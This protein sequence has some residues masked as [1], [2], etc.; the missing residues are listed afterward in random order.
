MSVALNSAAVGAGSIVSAAHKEENSVSS[1]FSTMTD[2]LV[3]TG[4]FALAAALAAAAVLVN[5][6]SPQG[7]T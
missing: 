6:R 4:F 1:N 7:R 5:R 3:A 2:V